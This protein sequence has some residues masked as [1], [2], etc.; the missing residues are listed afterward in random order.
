MIPAISPPTDN[1]YKLISLMGLGVLILGIANSS[2]Q[3][4]TILKTKIEIEYVE[5]QIADTIH[6][7]NRVN[8][9]EIQFIKTSET[10]DISELIAELN[11]E[12]QLSTYQKP[13]S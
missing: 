7:Y 1:L 9:E 2:T 8:N 6:F 10:K 4:E 13:S 3:S 5:R 12:E 11:K